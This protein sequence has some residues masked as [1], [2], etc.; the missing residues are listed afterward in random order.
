M[1]NY[2]KLISL[3]HLIL[4]LILINFLINIVTINVFAKEDSNGYGG[5]NNIEWVGTWACGLQT[6]E[7]YNL[8]PSPGLKGNTLRQAIHVSIGG[9]RLRLK[10]SNE[11]GSEPVIM[12]SISIAEYKGNGEIDTS[13]NKVL[14]FMKSKTVTIKPG[15]YKWSDPFEFNLT[16]LSNIAISIFFIDVNGDITGHPGSR[17]TSYIV[18]GNKTDEGSL[19]YGASTPHW[20]FISALD[21]VAED[22]TAAII[23]LGNSITDGRGSTTDGNDR[24]TDQ[25]AKRLQE[26]PDT[27]NIAILNLGIG[28]NAVLGGGLGPTA[29]ERFDRDVLGQNGA[30]WVIVFEGVNDIGNC[31]D[32]ESLDVANGLIKAYEL[33]ID[34]AHMAGLKIY[35]ATITPFKGH[36]YYSYE[37]EQA[38][39]MVNEWIRSSGKFDAVLDFDAVVRDTDDNSKLLSIYDSGD[40]LHLNPTG[41]KALADA[42]DLS[43]FSYNTSKMLVY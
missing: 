6:V 27:D 8:P 4:I 35:G 10:I 16:P 36:S 12:N 34:K 31:K 40:G 11:F 39:I 41:Y 30:R 42:V 1:K 14:T 26:N 37:H 43:L 18:A 9:K 29:L 20:Y 33:F 38:R 28:G 19:S 15:G 22:N 5:Y 25:L 13:T 32:S 23:A 2:K 3:T 7:E 17:T 21:V 24:W